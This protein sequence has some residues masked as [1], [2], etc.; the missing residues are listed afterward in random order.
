MEGTMLQFSLKPGLVAL[1]L[2]A[3]AVSASAQIDCPV[4]GSARPGRPPLSPDKVALN[5][6][7]NRSFYPLFPPQITIDEMRDL[8]DGPD[9][10][11]EQRGVILEGYLLGFKKEGPES[12]NCYRNDLFD[13]HVWMGKQTRATK[14]ARMALRKRAVV[15]EPTPHMQALHST[16]T[17]QNLRTIEGKRIRVTGWLMFD[18]EHPEQVGR[19]R[20]T[21]WEVH[22]VTRIEVLESGQWIDF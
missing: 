11:F 2:F 13:F 10:N 21:L 3:S 19:T 20:G 22:P 8:D 12:P 14:K 6:L 1:V 16:W 18:W 9:P 17:S 7:K 5:L 15:V 4:E